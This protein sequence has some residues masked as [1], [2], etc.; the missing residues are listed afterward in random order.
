MFPWENF[1]PLA[2]ESKLWDVVIIGAGMGGSTVGL[3]LA[4]QGLSV[5][6]LERGRPAS[7]F[8]WGTET[9]DADLETRGAWPRR[10]AFESNGK[11]ASVRLTLGTGPGGSSAIYGAALERLRRIDFTQSHHEGDGT[12]PMPDGWPLD[13]DAFAAYYHQAEGLFGVRGTPDPSDPDDNSALRTPPPLSERDAHFMKSF[14]A[15]GLAPYRLHVGIEYKTG[16]TECLGLPCPNDCKAEGSSRA[17]KPAL[18]EHGAQILFDCE[19]VRVAMSDDQVKHVMAQCDGR[20]LNVRGRVVILAAGALCTPVLLINSS[21]DRWPR[22]IGNDNDLVG[23]GLMFHA[24][25]FVALWPQVKVNS[26]G[27]GKTLSSRAFYVVDGKKLGGLQ[28]LGLPISSFTIYEFLYGRYG[29]Y[30]PFRAPLVRFAV[31]AATR[32]IARC[33]REAGLFATIVEDFPYWENRVYPD[34]TGGG[35]STSIKYE[36]TKELTSRFAMMR[37]L[38]RSR[39][40][41]HRPFF[42][43]GS[44]ILNFGHPS[45]T[46]RF[47]S[48]PTISVLNSENQVHGVSNLYV[49]DASFFPSSGGANPSLTV[50]ANALR[51]AERIGQRLAPTSHANESTTGRHPFRNYGS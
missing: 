26:A 8:T 42:L 19:V 13:Y 31:K 30:L 14:E 25:D 47:G 27:P 1:K 43:T 15:S 46:C 24:S 21:S 18:S 9:T 17:L 32:I 5:L 4:K 44:E 50:A 29:R 12:K 6:F 38:L 28:S 40:A 20:S 22:G 45:G 35:G 36:R 11:K 23:R 7:K 51:V 3:S 33:F 48:D 16:C 49:V 10:I 41:R 34:P 2:P 39:L 37:R